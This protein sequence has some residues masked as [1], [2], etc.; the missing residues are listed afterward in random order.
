[1]TDATLALKVVD[2]P[3]A[4]S[5]Q[6]WNR[7]A[8]TQPFLRH[9]FFAALHD[10]GCCT[11][12]TGWLAQF[13]TVWRGDE[14]A[15][16]APLYV[17]NHS[18]GEYVF[19]WSWAD[20]YR[21]AGAE[22]YPKLVACVPFTPVAGARLLATDDAARRVLLSG[23]LELARATSSLHILF[24][25]ESEVHLLRE[26][27]LLIRN[28]V[29]FHWQNLGYADFDAFLAALSHDKRK[30]IKQE[31]RKLSA[32]GIRFRRLVGTEIQDSDWRFFTR[33]YK[34]TYRAHYSTPYL[35]FECF[36]RLGDT[37]GAHM[38]LVVASKDDTPVAAALNVIDGDRLYGR[39]WGS[40]GYVP[41][42][43]FETCYYQAIEYC[44]EQR[45]AIFEGGA[46]G[47]HKLARGFLPART[48]S[49]HWLRHPQFAD[50]VDR[51]LEREK[52]G[53]AHY[54]DELTEHSPFRQVS[55][56]PETK[57]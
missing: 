39:Y 56:V 55:D 57:G 21:R 40:A 51:F 53:I 5:A 45:L 43:H 19:D 23:M 9:E 54:I 15:A 20:A 30:K 12:A 4:I 49:A 48:W 17:K 42:L 6:A 16:L 8:G 2:T 7:L 13:V 52:Q 47:E 3:R 31:R 34:S 33:C 26:Q 18:Y 14:L 41:G 35:N 1:M 28:G 46:Q 24:P 32:A 27:G 11:P 37:L 50:A 38:L 44:I 10:T 22:Y 25:S 29:Q 36:K